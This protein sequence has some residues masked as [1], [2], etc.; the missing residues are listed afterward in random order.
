[1]ARQEPDVKAI[2][3]L[4]DECRKPDMDGEAYCYIRTIKGNEEVAFSVL[5]EKTSRPDFSECGVFWIRIEDFNKMFRA[6]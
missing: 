4:K 2:Y 6:I 5:D 3:V 1:M